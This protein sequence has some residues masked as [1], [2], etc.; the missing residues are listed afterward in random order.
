MSSM[1]WK[2]ELSLGKRESCKTR[3]SSLQKSAA[4]SKIH[5]ADVMASEKATLQRNVSDWFK[6]GAP[7]HCEECFLDNLGD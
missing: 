6:V 4:N 7:L 2:K 1:R 3:K 5:L